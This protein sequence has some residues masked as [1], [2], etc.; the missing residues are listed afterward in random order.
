MSCDYDEVIEAQGELEVQCGGGHVKVTSPKSPPHPTLHYVTVPPP[1]LPNL[2][3]VIITLLVV[4][5]FLSKRSSKPNPI[6]TYDSQFILQTPPPSLKKS[7]KKLTPVP[8]L[9]ES[10]TV[11][12]APLEEDGEDCFWGLG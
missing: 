6:Q 11:R 12:I 8:R 3:S 10:P 4:V 1:T 7:R 9:I 5:F 2:T